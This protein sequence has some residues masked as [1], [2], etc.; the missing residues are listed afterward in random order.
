MN[1]TMGI[2]MPIM[3]RNNR[4]AILNFI[5]QNPQLV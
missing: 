3:F 4:E 1:M 2:I 5:V